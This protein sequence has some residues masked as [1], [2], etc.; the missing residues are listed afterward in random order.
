MSLTSLLPEFWFTGPGLF[1]G[2]ALLTGL[3]LR[4]MPAEDAAPAPEADPADVVDLAP[5]AVVHHPAAAP[6]RLPGARRRALCVGINYTGT[7]AQLSGCINDATNMRA[8]LRAHYDFDET[9]LLTDETQALPTRANLRRA[10]AWLVDG[11]RRGDTL[12]LHFSGHGGSVRDASGDEVDCADETIVPLDYVRAGQI[13][14][15]ELFEWLVRPLE[16][17]GARLVALFDSCHSGTGLDLRLRYLAGPGGVAE[18]RGPA[19]RGSPAEVLFFSGC[20]DA[21][22]SSD[23]T[24]GGQSYGAF[25]NAFL[26]TLRGAWRQPP[27][28]RAFLLGVNRHLAA[29][30]FAQK[31]QMCSAHPMD[32]DAPFALLA[33]P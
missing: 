14:D 20:A 31:P 19:E 18:E 26:A 12:F 10:C 28:Y 15:D 3:A 1:L 30:R 2:C 23:V 33:A 16:Q 9:L 5:H 29:Q 11:S 27:S 6:N 13:L 7:A 4:Y 17:T 22:T 21:Q 8:M 25:T 32:L 24:D